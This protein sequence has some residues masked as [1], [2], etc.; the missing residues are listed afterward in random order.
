MRWISASVSSTTRTATP[1]MTST[2]SARSAG[3]G[4]ASSLCLKDS[5]PQLLA[6]IRFIFEALRLL[7]RSSGITGVLTV[8]MLGSAP[9]ARADLFQELQRQ[10]LPL[11]GGVVGH[12]H[13]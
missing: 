6:M 3:T 2:P 13:C 1:A 7:F 5:L 12:T 4:S 10:R 9:A 11:P 8:S